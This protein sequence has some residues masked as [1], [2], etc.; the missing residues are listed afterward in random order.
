MGAGVMFFNS[1]REMLVMQTKY[2][3]GWTIPG[4]TVEKNESPYSTCVREIQEEIGMVKKELQF[5]AID[6]KC[7][8]GQMENLQFMF[9]GGKL[10]EKE[11][12]RIKLDN[13]ELVRFKFVAP[14]SAVKLLSPNLARGIP[15]C[16]EAIKN[17]QAVYLENGAKKTY[18]QRN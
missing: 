15:P 5:V 8:K 1:R 7:L 10:T 12:D 2:R 4:G 13:K 11:I 18:D 16:L 3:Q 14:G 9:Y 6:Y 17:N